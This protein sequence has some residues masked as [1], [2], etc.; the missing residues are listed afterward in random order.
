MAPRYATF[1]NILTAH[2]RKRLFISFRSKISSC[3]SLRRPRFAITQVYFHHPMTFSA[4]IL[5]FCAEFLFDLVNLTFDLLTLAMSHELSFTR[6]MHIAYQCLHPTIIRSW[7]MCDSIW[8]H[9]RHQ[10]RSIHMRRV[11]WPITGGQK[12]STFLKSLNRI[13]LF[14]VSLS[15]RHDED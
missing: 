9:Y 3:H 8:S 10:E 12:W 4:Y 11:T 14:T 7:V 5:C 1:I 15:G 6:P 13:Y 2:A